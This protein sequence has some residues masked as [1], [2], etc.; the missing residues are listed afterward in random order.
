[1]VDIRVDIRV[2][3]EFHL[4]T[5]LLKSQAATDHQ[6]MVLDVLLASILVTSF[7]VIKLHSS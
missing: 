1:M 6:D 3:M 2:D 7:K 5:A 4:P